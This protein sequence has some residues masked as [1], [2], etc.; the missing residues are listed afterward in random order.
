MF[1]TNKLIHLALWILFGL[2]KS[3]DYIPIE[4]TFEEY[5]N[6][7]IDYYLLVFIVF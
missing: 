5:N 2:V 1:R 4:I 7:L 6:I 3:Y